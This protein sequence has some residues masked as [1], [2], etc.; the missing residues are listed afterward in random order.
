ME[1]A[2]SSI[3]VEKTSTIT[4]SSLQK[5]DSYWDEVEGMPVPE[6]IPNIDLNDFPENHRIDMF[7]LARDA[8]VDIYNPATLLTH[9][10]S[11]EVSNDKRRELKDL[12][13]HGLVL[14]AAYKSLD[15]RHMAPQK[16]WLFLK[17]LGELNDN[18]Y[19][20][21]RVESKEKLADFVEKQYMSLDGLEI[22][23]ATNKSLQDHYNK[24]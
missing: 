10:Q 17:L 24:E 11:D 6:T 1:A 22:F 23:S 15:G 20:P 19:S 12:R 18:Y 3:P 2:D 14:R 4:G 8:W 9:L 16:H 21:Q 7:N 5:L 13:K